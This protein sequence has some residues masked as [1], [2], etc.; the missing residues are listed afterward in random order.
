M[1]FRYPKGNENRSPLGGSLGKKKQPVS[2]KRKET[3]YLE[4]GKS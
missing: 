2:L 3:E 4:T 1:Y